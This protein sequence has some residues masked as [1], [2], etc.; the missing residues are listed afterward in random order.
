MPPL[1]LLTYS[2]HG[3]NLLGDLVS[4]TIIIIVV[5]IFTI[6]TIIV[7]TITTPIR[8]LLTLRLEASVTSVVYIVA[9]PS[10]QPRYAS[11]F[12]WLAHHKV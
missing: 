6:I 2:H 12:V 11:H 7:M 3:G 10:H 8:A 5:F 9:H 1:P 4:E